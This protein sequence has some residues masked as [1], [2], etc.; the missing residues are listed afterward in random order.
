MDAENIRKKFPAYMANIQLPKCA[1]EQ[2]I[3]VYRACPTR[4]IERNSFLNSF[5]ENGFK[6]LPNL[7]ED[8]PQQYCLST[9]YKA[10]DLK[11]FVSINARF[12]PPYLLVKGV[13]EPSC[14]VS[15]RTNEWKKKGKRNYH[16]DWWLYEEAEPWKY[17][18]EVDY[19]Q[20]TK[21]TI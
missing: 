12:Q 4:R 8:D 13:T 11:R 15:C 5:E 3:V 21:R 7:P 9:S 16:V 18:E 19:E 1:K 14:G 6:P 17:F 10:K 2:P 20:E